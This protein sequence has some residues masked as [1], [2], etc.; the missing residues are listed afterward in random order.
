MQTIG[1]NQKIKPPWLTAP[2]RDIHTMLILLK[3]H[4]LLVEYDF[5]DRLRFL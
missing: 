4:Y 3:A 2:E 1:T 5:R